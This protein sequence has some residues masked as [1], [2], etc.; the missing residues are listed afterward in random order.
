MK[1]RPMRDRLVV[2]RIDPEKHVDTIIVDGNYIRE[3]ANEALKVFVAPL[4]N[5]YSAA[6][7][8]ISSS[9]EPSSEPEV[10]SG[11]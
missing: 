1:F 10:K 3:Q 11:D 6:F 4:S 2:N 7:G 5:V 8:P 9:A